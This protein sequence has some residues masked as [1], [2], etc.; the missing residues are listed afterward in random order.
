MS[1]AWTLEVHSPWVMPWRTPAASAIE[2][3]L[4]SEPLLSHISRI[5]FSE[6]ER[7]AYVDLTII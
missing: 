3:P 6:I 4:H 7:P 2:M 1:D 5:L